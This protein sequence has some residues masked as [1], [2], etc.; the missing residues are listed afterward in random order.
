MTSNKWNCI[1]EFK[2]CAKLKITKIVDILIMSILYIYIH[3]KI[4]FKKSYL[5]EFLNFFTYF[6][7]GF[8]ILMIVFFLPWIIDGELDFLKLSSL[9]VS[10]WWQH[11]LSIIDTLFLAKNGIIV[12]ILII[13]SLLVLI[14]SRGINMFIYN[15]I[16]LA[17]MTFT[18]HFLGEEN[19]WTYNFF[20]LII[21]ILVYIFITLLLYSI[22]DKLIN[23]TKFYIKDKYFVISYLVWKWYSFNKIL[24][25]YNNDYKP[26]LDLINKK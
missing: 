15:M 6:I 22:I 12:V 25:L 11:Y 24:E 20:V 10:E 14:F 13:S 1:N 17:S 26:I 4:F 16:Y 21:S 7:I 2:K 19:I 18:W 5:F 3:V 9:S 23:K 8:A